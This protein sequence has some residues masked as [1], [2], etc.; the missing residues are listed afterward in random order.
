M[1]EQVKGY[2]TADGRFFQSLSEANYE[3]AKFRLE[4]AMEALGIS[5]D[6]L[7]WIDNLSMEIEE[8]IRTRSAHEHSN[9][10][11]MATEPETTKSISQENLTNAKR[12][13]PNAPITRKI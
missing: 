4:R 1:A 5:L 11:L 3:E 8:Y 2:M 6:S 7:E 12:K 13:V 10:K 9:I